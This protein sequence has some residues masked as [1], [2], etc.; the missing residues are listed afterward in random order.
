MNNNTPQKTC[1]VCGYKGS[2]VHEYPTYLRVLGRDTTELQCDDI[3][4]CLDRKY[5]IDKRSHTEKKEDFDLSICDVKEE[6][7]LKGETC[8]K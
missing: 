1:A 8:Q 2:D 3:E 5:G 4:A 6:T 7:K